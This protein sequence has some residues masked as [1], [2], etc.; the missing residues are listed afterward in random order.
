MSWFTLPR[1]PE[2]EVM[3]QRDGVEAYASAASQAHLDAL[4]DAFVDRVLS[5]GIQKGFALDVGTGPGQIPLK[6]ARRCSRLHLVGLDRSAAMLRMARETALKS[7]LGDC[8][9]FMLA[10]A[11][12]LCFPAA[13]FD[14]VISN[15]L[16]HHLNNPVQAFN[17]MA[18]VTKPGGKILVRDLRRP[19]RLAFAAH[20]AW[21]GRH[22]SG[23][24][25]ALCEDSVRAAYTPA[26]LRELAQK[27]GLE[28]ARLFL[29]GGAHMGIE[30]TARGTGTI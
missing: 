21:H 25:K 10:D 3:E 29:E 18:R 11:S 26:E 9:E 6:I 19:S 8:V 27:A 14:L 20:V 22:Y 7:G 30:N 12:R 16:L 17:E 4:D 13:S 1:K 28:S 15:S 2:A 24:M 5:L 23:R